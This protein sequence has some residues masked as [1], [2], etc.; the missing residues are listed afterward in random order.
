MTV[1]QVAA[2]LTELYPLEWA[3]DWD[4]VG[5][6][7]GDPALAVTRILCAVDCNRATVGEAV[8]RH[9][10]L[11][12]SHHPVLLRGVSAVTTTTYHGRLVIDLI[13]HGVAVYV[14]HT[15]ADVASP[16]V[17]D[18]LAGRLGLGEVRPLMP[19][20]G[21]A[22]GGGRGYGRIGRLPEPLPLAEVV[23][24]VAK[25]LPVTV[26]GVK[27]A[28]DPLRMITT[29][30]VAG[31]AGDDWLDAAAEAGVDAYLT[32]D[33]RHHRASEALGIGRPALIEAAHF[34]TE[35]P[36]LDGL[37]A[38]LRAT[39]EV[40]TMVS[41]LVTDPWTLHLNPARSVAK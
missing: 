30:A 24:R 17:S 19:A 39:F 1:G 29:L 41:D 3:A 16:G 35:R 7:I 5:L 14:A 28:G 13:R 12:V 34:A 31:G 36:F 21:S 23:K 25:T 38:Q 18:A 22:A 33:L 40:E 26:A 15:N 2:A 20:T 37:A 4:R 27:A 32:A 10:N 11:I 6:A 9:A 8:A